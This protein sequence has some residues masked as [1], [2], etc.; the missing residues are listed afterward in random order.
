MLLF[1]ITVNI[2]KAT[3]NLEKSLIPYF[4]DMTKYTAVSFS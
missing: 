1:A 4:S 3:A 2:V